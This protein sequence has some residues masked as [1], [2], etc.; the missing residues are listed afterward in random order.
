[1]KMKYDDDIVDLETRYEREP[2]LGSA[3]GAG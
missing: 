1:M 2:P 3:D